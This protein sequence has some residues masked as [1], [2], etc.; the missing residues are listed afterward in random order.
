[1]PN[2]LT[3]NVWLEPWFTVR[4]AG[5]KVRVGG[6][7]TDNSASLEMLPNGVVTVTE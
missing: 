3:D 7:I 4:V 6:R 1:M 2:G 5:V